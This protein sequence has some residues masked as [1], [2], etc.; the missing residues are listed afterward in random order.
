ML[1]SFLE[2][3]YALTPTILKSLC[4]VNMAKL[5]SSPLFLTEK[6]NILELTWWWKYDQNMSNKWIFDY[7]GLRFVFIDY[8]IQF[9]AQINII[10]I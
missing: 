2:G 6:K 3:Q 9:L 5:I 4:W 1:E 10:C 7:S 8:F